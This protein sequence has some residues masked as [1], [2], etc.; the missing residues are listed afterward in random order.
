VC[1]GTAENSPTE[2]KKKKTLQKPRRVQ[3]RGVKSIHLQPLNR[4]CALTPC[5]RVASEYR[6]IRD[7]WL[8]EYFFDAWPYIAHTSCGCTDSTHD[9]RR[10]ESEK[11]L[12]YYYNTGGHQV[13]DIKKDIQ[14]VV[15]IS[16]QLATKRLITALNITVIT[17]DV[18]SIPV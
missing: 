15:T 11:F 4:R 8:V 18:L 7:D 17:S 13:P 14:N 6:I 12:A 10:P 3:I 5:S 16:W 2:L 1:G 9:P